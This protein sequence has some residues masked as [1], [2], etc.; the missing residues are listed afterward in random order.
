[1]AVIAGHKR[2]DCPFNFV[3]IAEDSSIDGLLL[4]GAVEAF[5]DTVGLG[6]LDEGKAWGDAPEGD[7]VLKMV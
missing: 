7:L 1:M 6:L 2:G 3:E 4:E 5:S